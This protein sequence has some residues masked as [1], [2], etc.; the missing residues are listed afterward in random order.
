M[1][2]TSPALY[3]ALAAFKDHQE[4]RA[5]LIIGGVWANPEAHALWVAADELQHPERYAVAPL[6]TLADFAEEEK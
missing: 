5:N 6:K 3:A 1:T 2:T 4:A